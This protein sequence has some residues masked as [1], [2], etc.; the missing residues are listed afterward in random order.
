[1]SL[2]LFVFNEF[3]D[4]IAVTKSAEFVDGSIFFLDFSRPI[5]VIRWLGVRNNFFGFAVGLHVPV[6]HQGEEQGGYVFSVTCTNPYFKD[7]RKLWKTR[8]PTKNPVPTSKADAFQIIGTFA[9][10]FPED[11]S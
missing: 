6:I 11:H 8:Y 4:R 2:Q 7:F 5:Q 1:M 10:Q 9:L 3:P